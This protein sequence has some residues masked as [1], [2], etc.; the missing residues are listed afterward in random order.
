MAVKPSMTPRNKA[1]RFNPTAMAIAGAAVIGI[2]GA[3]LLTGNPFR[4]VRLAYLDYSHTPAAG[5]PKADPAP[6]AP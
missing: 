2:V 5:A 6:K 1:T 4:A 3:T